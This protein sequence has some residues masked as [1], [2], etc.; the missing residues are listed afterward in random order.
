MTAAVSSPAGYPQHAIFHPQL[1]E[2]CAMLSRN[3]T[4]LLWVLTVVLAASALSAEAHLAD[5]RLALE[6]NQV[7][8]SF[9]LREAFSEKTLE[10]IQTGLPTG[11]L[12]QFRLDRDRKRWFDASLETCDLQVVAMYNAVTGEYLVNYK[13]DGELIESRVVR[14][15]EDLELALTRFEGVAIFSLD[16]V[17]SH[18]RLLVRV[19]ADL[20]SKT[21]L[22]FIPTRVTT[23]WVRS[24]K[25]RP[26]A[27][28]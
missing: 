9:E 13:L 21:L 26:P 7:V 14:E 8:L 24:H 20:G 16:D 25:F 19:R 28:E 22:G 17:A 4:L 3:R 27:T 11:F 15:K 12:Y 23:E 6:N 18:D 1:L 2:S 10:R 5:V